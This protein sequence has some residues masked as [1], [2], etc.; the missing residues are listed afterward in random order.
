MDIPLLR[1]R[2]FALSKSKFV[3]V[4]LQKVACCNLLYNKLFNSIGTERVKGNTS[5]NVKGKVW[6][7]SYD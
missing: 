1:R 2:V 5:P 4:F 6:L 7:I 3:K